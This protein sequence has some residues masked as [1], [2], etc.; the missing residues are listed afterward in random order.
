MRQRAKIVGAMG[1]A[2]STA[3]AFAWLNGLSASLFEAEELE[4]DR[5]ANVSARPPAA[6][7]SAGHA[8]PGQGVAPPAGAAT[9]PREEERR[10]LYLHDIDDIK[11]EIYAREIDTTDRLHLLDDLVQTGDMDTRELWDRDWSGVDDW[12]SE[13]NGFTLQ[14]TDD[15]SLVFHPDQATMDLYSFYETLQAYE[16]DEATREFVSEIEYYGKPIRNVLKFIN[17]DTLVMMTIS[18]EKV[19]LNI[20]GDSAHVE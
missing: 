14:K 3:V 18:G 5:R 10:V 19:D 12:K 11:H 16:Y 13:S 1:L 8:G 9:V 20:Y 6:D 7:S 4:L 17:E 15:G 2:V